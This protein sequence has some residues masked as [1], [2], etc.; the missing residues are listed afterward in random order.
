MTR[1]SYNE[2]VHL[3]CVDVDGYLVCENDRELCKPLLAF[4]NNLYVCFLFTSSFAP[5]ILE[6]IGKQFGQVVLKVSG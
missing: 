4:Y 2:T 3:D 5:L 1:E 6:P